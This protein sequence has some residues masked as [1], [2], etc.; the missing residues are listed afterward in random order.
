MRRKFVGHDCE[1]EP[2]IH[3]A[4]DDE[5]REQVRPND[6]TVSSLPH[7]SEHLGEIDVGV[8]GCRSW[9]EGVAT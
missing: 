3:R 7:I 4:E 9:C 6:E 2:S 8:D 5:Q 1:R